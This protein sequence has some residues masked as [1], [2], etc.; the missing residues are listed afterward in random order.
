MAINKIENLV[1]IERFLEEFKK[2]FA[3][4]HKV[5]FRPYPGNIAK[6]E[7]LKIVDNYK[8]QSWFIYDNSPKLSAEIMHKSC[9]LIGDHSSLVYTFPLTCLKPV[10]LLFSNKEILKNEFVGVRFYNPILHKIAT[11][12]K[13]CLEAFCEVLKED[14]KKRQEEIKK[15]RVKEVF[16]LGNSS[17]FIAKFIIKKHKDLK[18]RN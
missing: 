13:E 3:P 7:S 6:N 1:I 4:K 12:A 10:I 15:Y 17:E 9:V 8:E 11:N 14:N 5:Y 18:C 2:K 16:N